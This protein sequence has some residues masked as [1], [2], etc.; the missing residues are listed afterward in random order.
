MFGIE[1]LNVVVGLIFVYLLF[2]LFV[3]I[4]NEIL[5]SLLQIRGT[6][7]KSIIQNMV[8]SELVDKIYE[9]PKIQTFLRRTGKLNYGSKSFLEK[10]HHGI[11][12]DEIPPEDFTNALIETIKEEKED[13]Q[14]ISQYLKSLDTQSSVGLNYLASLAEEVEQDLNAFEKE[15]K[16]WY[17]KVMGYASDWYKRKLRW[18]L[19]ALGLVVA[20]AFNVDSISIFKT[21][22]DNPQARQALIA[23]TEA[24]V[25]DYAN[26]NGRIVLKEASDSTVMISHKTMLSQSLNELKKDFRTDID[27]RYYKS[28]KNDIKKKMAAE[29]NW[30]DTTSDGYKDHLVVAVEDSLYLIAQDS[31]KAKYPQA[32]AVDSA[33]NRLMTL[34]EQ[35]INK[36]ASTLGIGWD[37]SKPRWGLHWYSIIGWLIT[38]L[39]ISLGAPFWFDTLKKVINIKSEITKQ[40]GVKR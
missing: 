29:E 37:T 39:A 2:S 4:I 13:D 11:L 31:L 20:V 30:Q 5:S 27:N 38:A 21:L 23:Q 22:S 1:A 10:H 25:D 19:I 15:V 8:S 32:V 12:P 34:Q 6:E 40:K 24:F 26:E 35:Q 33:Y 16:Q 17:D 7:L 9:N 14:T 36:A 3:S 28:V 18:I